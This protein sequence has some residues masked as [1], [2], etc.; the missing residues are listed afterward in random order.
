MDVDVSES[1]KRAA[2]NCNDV[3]DKSQL[4]PLLL[5]TGL[6]EGIPLALSVLKNQDDNTN[7]PKTQVADALRTMTRASGDIQQISRW[8][9][10]NGKALRWNPAVG[11][12]E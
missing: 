2:G 5:K 3:W 9:E 6:S 12:F 7:Y 1:L 10:D 8:L 4:C 11:R